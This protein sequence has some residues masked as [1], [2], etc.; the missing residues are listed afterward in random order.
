[1]TSEEFNNKCDFYLGEVY[2]S[3][4][5]LYSLPKIVEN[6]KEIQVM[7]YLMEQNLVTE[8]NMEFYRI[9]QFG[10]QVYETGGWLKYLQIQKKET[11][12][13]KIKEKKNIRN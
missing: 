1:M 5:G 3:T 13:K 9:T 10:R 4:Y 11:E 7:K 2:K 6:R 8:S 12:E